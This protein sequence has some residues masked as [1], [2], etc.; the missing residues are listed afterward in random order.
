M[1]HFGAGECIQHAELLYLWNDQTT[2]RKGRRCLRG[3]YEIQLSIRH[4]HL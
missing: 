4:V 3:K 2:E 1:G